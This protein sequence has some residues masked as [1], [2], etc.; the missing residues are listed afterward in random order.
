MQGKKL[1]LN[2]NILQKLYVE[3]YWSTFAI[4]KK[5]NC[6]QT[7]V[8]RYLEKYGIPRRRFQDSVKIT[9][10]LGRANLMRAKK[11]KHGKW[12][13]GRTKDKR[14]YIKV[15]KPGY[16]RAHKN[17]Y[18]YEHIIVWEKANK[19]KLPKN[20]GVH[21]IN[22]IKDDNRPEN[23]KALPNRSHNKLA[24]L[25]EAKRKIC[26][27]ETEIILLRKFGLRPI[28]GIPI[29]SPMELGYR[30][31]LGHSNIIWSEFLEHI[32]CYKCEK[33][34]HYADDCVLI[35]DKC[36]PKH[37]PKQPRIIKGINNWTKDGNG[38]LNIPKKFLL[39]PK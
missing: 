4:A 26:K 17:G 29:D 33:D 32:W 23:L 14:G 36:N 13:G 11:S 20:W 28:N 27:L 6:G 31:P 3:E 16:Y 24:L 35:E 18:V 10:N 1:N 25:T 8:K 21:H 19:K 2:K 12:R 7:S 39:P 9:Y 34:Y 22:G 38:F 37:L 15:C 5:L 30:C